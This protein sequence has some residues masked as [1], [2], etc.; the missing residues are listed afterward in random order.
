MAEGPQRVGLTAALG[1][2]EER[3]FLREPKCQTKKKNTD[4]LNF[5]ILSKKNLKMIKVKMKE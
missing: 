5:K 1:D 2:E 4:K 3:V